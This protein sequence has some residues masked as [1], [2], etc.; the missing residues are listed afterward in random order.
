M[1]KHNKISKNRDMG[2]KW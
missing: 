1:S 2:I